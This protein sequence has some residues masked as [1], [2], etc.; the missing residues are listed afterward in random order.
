MFLLKPPLLEESRQTPFA[1]LERGLQA[2]FPG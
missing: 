1:L 2:W